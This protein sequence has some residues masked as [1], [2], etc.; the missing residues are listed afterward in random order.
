[1]KT[2]PILFS[3]S[4]VQSILNG[5]KTQTRRELKDNKIQDKDNTIVFSSKLDDG[6]FAFARMWRG[7]YAETYHTKPKCEVGDIFWVRETWQYH[8]HCVQGEESFVYKSDNPQKSLMLEEKWKPS[9]FMPK[10]A[11]RIFLKVTNVRVE[12]LQDIS[13]EDSKAEG[14]KKAWI[15]NIPNQ[16]KYVNYINN[17]KGSL[18]AK[19]S[20]ESLW[21][22]INGEDSW[23]KN[24][25]VWVYD[26]EITEKP[27]NFL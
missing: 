16:S 22:S 11:C 20:F 1:M 2:P 6:T 9:I 10:Q 23:N 27:E 24:P 4:M 8:Y 5:S 3:T 26:F 15:S 18:N 7:H 25:F 19:K 12:R 21:H 14:I 17:G 13:E